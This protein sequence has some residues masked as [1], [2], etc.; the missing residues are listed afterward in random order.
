MAEQSSAE[1]SSLSI[2]EV[3]CRAK[4]YD[5]ARKNLN[6]TISVLEDLESLGQSLCTRMHRHM[7]K[8]S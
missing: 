2:K 6:T 4:K 7:C 8:Y 5:L 3:L 1:S